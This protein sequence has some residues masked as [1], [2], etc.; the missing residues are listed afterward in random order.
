MA[1]SIFL[2]YGGAAGRMKHLLEESLN[3][4][5]QNPCLK[6]CMGASLTTTMHRP[7]YFSTAL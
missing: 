3:I 2:I 4:S 7:V 5:D 6:L 1:F